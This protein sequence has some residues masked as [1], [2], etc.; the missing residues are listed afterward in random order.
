MSLEQ[1]ISKKESHIPRIERI[2][3]LLPGNNTL[4]AIRTDENE[5]GNHYLPLHEEL[6]RIAE[7]KGFLVP[8]K[9]RIIDT[10]SS[11]SAISLAYVAKE[12]GYPIKLI[13]PHELEEKVKKYTVEQIRRHNG[14]V[15][16][17]DKD[18]MKNHRY[19]GACAK[20]LERMIKT[21]E[22]DDFVLN[23]SR[24]YET[25]DALERVIEEAWEKA[26][27]PK[28]DYLVVALGNGATILAPGKY[29]KEKFGT[30]VV[31]WE[32]FTSGLAWEMKEAGTTKVQ[33]IRNGPYEKKFGLPKG[34]AL[35]NIYG[36]GVPDVKFPFLKAA[37]F[38]GKL[39]GMAVDQ[40]KMRMLRGE[41]TE[42]E[43]RELM[44]QD[45]RQYSAVIDEVELAANETMI[46]NFKKAG[47]SEEL[48]KSLM[49]KGEITGYEATH[50][51]LLEKGYFVGRSAAASVAVARSIV[52]KHGIENSNIAVFFYDSMK[53][54]L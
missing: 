47:G 30:K 33:N 35:H 45:F 40:A 51:E 42:E 32:P 6:L 10:S 3:G 14:E 38:G 41:A 12:M 36:T 28:V 54:Y 15:L 20:Q 13:I 43:V 7:K 49:Q 4:Y 24:I 8:G 26:G 50:R 11:N 52:E 2:E 5:V 16:F 21:K 25:I 19:V 18:I 1:K 48:V 17:P 29:L 31:V 22:E 23:H 34:A 9:S 37:M 46:R 53:K 39:Y 27:N 44:K